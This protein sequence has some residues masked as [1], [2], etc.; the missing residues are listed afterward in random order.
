M[1]VWKRLAAAATGLA[2][3]AHET[4]E[5]SIGSLLKSL[6][7]GNDDCV[8]EHRVA[9]TIG[10]IALGAKMAK[11]DGVVTRDEVIAFT[12]VFKVPE[13]EMENVARIF[14]IAKQD[15]AGYEI[16]AR[17][18]AALLKSN[19]SL[20]EDV[21]EGLFHIAMADG[22]LHSNEEQFLAEVA[23]RF[24]FTDIEFGYMKARHVGSTK[25]SPYNILGIT[26]EISN[27]A[28]KIHYRKLVAEN[29]PDKMIARGVPPEFVA[30]ATKKIAAINAAYDELTKERHI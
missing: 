16:Y 7:C 18:L 20:L 4:E 23:K 25:D 14:N 22:L 11:A 13:G 30:I 8:P 9:F 21:L 19:S 26:P 15:V 28:L 10:V 2:A 12:E 17:Q 24:G 29:H 1:S 3:D 27:D 6:G 5:G